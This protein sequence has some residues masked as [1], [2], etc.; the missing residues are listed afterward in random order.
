MGLSVK[1]SRFGFLRTRTANEAEIELPHFLRVLLSMALVSRDPGPTCVLLP[2]TAGIVQS[3]AILAS[4]E[5]LA[6]DWPTLARGYVERELKPGT[7]V[8]QLPDGFVYEV[9]GKSDYEGT[10]G[11]MLKYI[12]HD[13]QSFQG[14]F[15][16]RARDTLRYEPTM[17]KRPVGRANNG[18]SVPPPLTA[19]DCLAGVR[20]YG[21]TA[22]IRNRVVLVGSRAEFE[23]ALA[24]CCLFL[25][26]ATGRVTVS[27]LADT[28]RWGSVDADG[29]PVVL[30]PTGSEGR[31]LVAVAGD[32]Q[33]AAAAT[34][35]AAVPPA[36]Q[37]VLTDRLDLVL[38]HLDLTERIAERQ[39]LILF[40]SARKRED[41][42]ILR[43]HGW[44]V[45]EPRPAMLLPPDG[46]VPGGIMIAGIDGLHDSAKAECQASINW[47]EGRSAI[48]ADAF[49]A[50]EGIG[51]ALTSESAEDDERLGNTLATIR[52]LFFRA[53]GWLQAPHGGELDECLRL[54]EI[55]LRER[56]YLQN[57]VGDEATALLNSFVKAMEDFVQSLGPGGTT[58]KGEALIEQA[59]D[60]VTGSCSK[61]V[62]VTGNR[63]S[64]DEADSLLRQYSIA[65]SCRVVSELAELH[66]T[67]H[68]TAFSILRRDIFAA[69]VDPWPAEQVSFIG[70][71]FETN[72]YRRRL[73][74]R[75]LLQQAGNLDLARRVQLT[76]L[77]PDLLG[78]DIVTPSGRIP[79]P[80][81]VEADRTLIAFDRVTAQSEW[82]WSNK[83]SIPKAAPGDGTVEAIVVRFVGRSWMA[84]TGE[85]RILALAAHP[86]QR[87]SSKA[88]TSRIETLEA[89]DL[90]PG[91]RLIVREAGEKDIIRLLAERR[92][93]S[94]R[95]A[96][97]RDAASLWRQAIRASGLS[98]VRIAEELAK[99][100]VRRHI[101]SIRSWLASDF[102]I[103]PRS[104]DDV[105][106]IGDAF[107]LAGKTDDAWNKCRDA[108]RELR[109]LHLSAG[110]RLSEMLSERCG[111]LL[112]E[113]TEA[114]IAVDLGLGTV[115]IIQVGDIEPDPVTVP[116]SI[117]N[118]LQWTDQA[119]RA[120]LLAGSVRAEA[121][122]MSAVGTQVLRHEHAQLTGGS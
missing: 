39:R 80:E 46:L 19:Y 29:W 98:P 53:T 118:R 102:L 10:D 84:M 20:S 45:W 94:K 33:T 87:D 110:A 104:D 28:F 52:A 5:C 13:K 43:K 14:S 2:V 1:M 63:A 60:M 38:R 72:I 120:R 77:S 54:L 92:L 112:F 101:A 115:W 95:Y 24:Q 9:A 42:A 105:M 40:G 36:S 7:R 103:G 68:V 75:A 56:K 121:A 22:L 93:G 57:F 17:R 66:D 47:V 89:A 41:A 27:S 78:P 116:T 55:L 51:A 48:L 90:R 61:P 49:T 97:L 35:G 31:P 86:A 15:Y 109:G 6:S 122:S 32:M 18:S 58:P 8:R 50:V 26:A 67:D 16:V 83:V 21:N 62:L 108:I 114:E 106:A 69:L 44:N 79:A 100:G 25:S 99:A 30:H 88:G 85:H 59:M 4:L 96:D 113:P 76:G 71:G 70:Y 111:S 117:T 3:V 73:A 37:I 81:Q 74:Q 64:R 12:G 65:L 119:W 107:P 91:M 23:R 82:H 11:L 34:L